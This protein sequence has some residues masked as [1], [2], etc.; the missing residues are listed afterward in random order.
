QQGET[1]RLRSSAHERRDR[2][3]LALIDV[4]RPLMRQHARNLEKYSRSDG[5]QR[6]KSQ[7]ISPRKLHVPPLY[8]ILNRGQVRRASQSIQNRKSIRQNAGA[9][10]AHQH[11]LHRRFVRAPVAPQKSAQHIKTQRHRL[12]AQE[13]HHQ[14]VAARQE[15]HPHGG[16]QHQRV[17]FAVLLVL[18]LHVPYGNQNH[19]RGGGQKQ[20][21]KKDKKRINNNGI[22]EAR[23]RTVRRRRIRPQHVER[24]AAEHHS[25]HRSQ[26]VPGFLR[27]SQQK[28]AQQNR[29]AKKY[30]HRFR[31]HQEEIAARLLEDLLPG[32]LFPPAPCARQSSRGRS[33]SNH[34]A[35]FS[36]RLLARR[37]PI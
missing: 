29:Q 30:Q 34:R 22:V 7:Q 3:R 16:K 11:V 19:Q 37:M 14:I 25:Q 26:C 33:R 27:L 24:P 36:R 21:A 13:Q 23:S 20:E 4:R 31:Q 1:R 28:I 17:I 6:E 2:R 9:E 8:R 10:R 15:H 18:N 32:H 12:Q 35:G 5:P